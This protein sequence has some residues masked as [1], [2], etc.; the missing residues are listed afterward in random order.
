MEHASDSA[1]TR[2]RTKWKEARNDRNRRS[3][4]WIGGRTLFENVN[5]KFTP[6]NAYGLIGA[7]GRE[8]HF[9]GCLSG[10]QSVDKGSVIMAKDLRLSTL[11]QDHFKYNE[12]RAIDTV[13]QGHSRLWR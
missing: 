1:L 6:G 4:S 9:P 13:I 11:E 3:D 2:N 10:V 5:V 12:E 8:V 7:N